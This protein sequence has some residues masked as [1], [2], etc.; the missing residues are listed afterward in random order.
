LT[1]SENFISRWSRLKHKSERARRAE[2]EVGTPS[3]HTV[4]ITTTGKDEAA[5]E[6]LETKAPGYRHFD[7][8][9]LPPIDSITAG[10]NISAFLQSGV[11]AT[12]ARAAFRRAWVSEPAIRDFIGIAENQWDFTDPTAIPGFGPLRMPENML[13]FVESALS[14]FDKCPEAFAEVGSSTKGPLSE[15]TGPRRRAVDAADQQAGDTYPVCEAKVAIL[16]SAYETDKAGMA[17]KGG[18]A[19]ANDRLQHHCRPHG[20]ALT[21]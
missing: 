16:S 21:K 1:E 10:T 7:P 5:P 11:P 20:S 14:T 9:C 4:E 8:A 3:P 2:S 15:T 12:L 13:G 6:S 19:T 17:A 18:Q